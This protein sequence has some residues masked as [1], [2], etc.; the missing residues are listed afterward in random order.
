MVT[1]AEPPAQLCAREKEGKMAQQTKYM[2]ALERSVPGK[3]AQ[4]PYLDK[5]HDPLSG[6]THLYCQAPWWQPKRWFCALPTEV[7]RA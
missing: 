7:D 1:L 5:E 6:A 4:C 3:C 2:V